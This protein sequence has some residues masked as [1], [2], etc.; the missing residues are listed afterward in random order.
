[1]LL[2]VVS[3]ACLWFVGHVTA[4]GQCPKLSQT[5]ESQG[6]NNNY[7]IDLLGGVLPFPFAINMCT[8]ISF[9]SPVYAMYTCWQGDNDAWEVTRT[10]YSDSAC[11]TSTS[12]ETWPTGSSLPGL[13][14]YFNC[15]GDNSYVSL[16]LALDDKTCQSATTVVGG[17]AGCVVAM[18]GSQIELYCD[19]S[20]ALAQI[21]LAAPPTVPG[22][23]GHN[24]GGKWSANETTFIPS[25][26][27]APS[28]VNYGLCDSKLFCAVW[29]FGST[30]SEITELLGHVVYGTM[31]TCGA[32]T[33]TTKNANTK[34]SLRV[35]FALSNILLALVVPLFWLL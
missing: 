25:S 14:G 32:I 24:V 3:W 15:A 20:M 7:A 19:D 21:F 10:T 12:T 18:T 1:M 4:Q 8:S 35:Q 30:C 27:I 6:G 29:T 17:L 28:A 2:S 13:Q 5:P 11:K 16:Q 23:N 34:S 26:S 9:T 22:A 31:N 33:T